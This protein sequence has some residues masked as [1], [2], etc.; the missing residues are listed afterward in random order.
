MTIDPKVKACLL[1]IIQRGITEARSL[2]LTGESKQAAAILDALDNIPK[3]LHSWSD[4]SEREIE[5][6]LHCFKDGYPSHYTDYLKLFQDRTSL[7]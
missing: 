4:N 1:G 3:H 5:I 7:F 2:T 6:Q